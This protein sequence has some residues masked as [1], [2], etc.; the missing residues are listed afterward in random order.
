MGLDALLEIVVRLP[1]WD[2]GV[3]AGQVAQSLISRSRAK[4]VSGG[5]GTHKYSYDL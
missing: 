3:G 4:V 1:G 5:C 2:R